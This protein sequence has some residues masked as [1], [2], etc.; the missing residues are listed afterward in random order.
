MNYTVNAKPYLR[1]HN[2]K[3][4]MVEL[5]LHQS[6]PYPPGMTFHQAAGLINGRIAKAY[7]VNPFLFER[8]WVFD[9]LYGRSGYY[10]YVNKNIVQLNSMPV[11]RLYNTQKVFVLN[12]LLLFLITGLLAYV[13]SKWY[14][15]GIGLKNFILFCVFVISFSFLFWVDVAATMHISVMKVCLN[16]G[17]WII[18]PYAL[19]GAFGI[20]SGSLVY[21]AIKKRSKCNESKYAHF[22][23]KQNTEAPVSVA[24]VHIVEPAPVV[25]E[26]P[27][28]QTAVVEE[29]VVPAPNEEVVPVPPLVVEE[30]IAVVEEARPII[31]GLSLVADPQA[32]QGP[33]KTD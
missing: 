32:P 11:H 10:A 33:A 12:G 8:F 29:Q 13:V 31:T 28:V 24:I 25:V 5:V 14:S 27:A 6:T 22:E 9:G 19:S 1:D 16:N 2:G 3:V 17:M 30:P 15:Y 4:E 7:V 18:F 26:E 23:V 20:F 21:R